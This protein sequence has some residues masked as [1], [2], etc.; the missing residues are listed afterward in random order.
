MLTRVLFFLLIVS[1]I[2]FK[3]SLAQVSGTDRAIG[4]DDISAAISLRSIPEIP[5]P[6]EAVS[7]S[8]D[9]SGI[10][11]DSALITWTL[12][13]VTIIS[14]RG[15]RTVEFTTKGIGS[16]SLISAQIDSSEGSFTRSLSISPGDID[17][18]WEGNTYAPPFYKGRT[19]W[20]NQSTITILAIPHVQRGGRTLAPSALIYKWTKNDSLLNTL[21]GVGKNSISFTDSILSLPQTIKVEVFVDKNTL[22]ASK[23]I[24]LSPVLPQVAI[25]ENNP[26]YGLMLHN[27]IESSFGFKEKEATFS[28][29]PL[30][31]SV[32]SRNS[33][34]LTFGWTT[35]GL[36][37]GQSKHEATFRA[38]ENGGGSAQIGVNVKHTSKV[39]Q[40]GEKVFE[41]QFGNLTN[42]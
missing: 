4:T 28:A 6:N 21:S 30:F 10:D 5:G 18:L 2:P 27:K 38:P 7:I 15:E 19:L 12:N 31:F 33:P 23:S 3:I 36:A 35:N 17:I 16:T 34:L 32:S 37:S 42:I 41:V 24:N 22:V 8:I 29:I 11:L 9:G 1:I 40:T 13:G 20:T 14:G 39:I 26:L 25:Y